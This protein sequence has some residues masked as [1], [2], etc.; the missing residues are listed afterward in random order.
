M[1]PSTA[2]VFNAPTE[3][4]EA[5]RR[6]LMDLYAASRQR[7]VIREAALLVHKR[8]MPDVH[9]VDLPGHV[10]HACIKVRAPPGHL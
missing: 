8:E 4:L 1:T 10:Q 2:L 7:A 6:P 9:I 5:Q 3:A